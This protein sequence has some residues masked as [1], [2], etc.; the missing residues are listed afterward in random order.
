MDGNI[1]NY[2][3]GFLS[4]YDCAKLYL[5]VTDPTWA[6]HLAE[7]VYV[8]GNP[9]AE[10]PISEKDKILNK[11]IMSRRANFARSGIPVASSFEEE[12]LPVVPVSDN[13]PADIYANVGVNPRYL[14]ITGDGGGTMI[15][16]NTVKME[17]CALIPYPNP[18]F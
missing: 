18:I 13:S 6:S 7:I 1:Y 16:S 8:F 12:W 14:Y 2:L 17:Q 15:Q 5:T 3:F 9:A 11:E 10:E 4:E